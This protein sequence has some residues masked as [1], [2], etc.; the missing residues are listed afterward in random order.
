MAARSN[1]DKVHE[2]R[3]RG[4]VHVVTPAWLHACFMSWERVDERSYALEDSPQRDEPDGGDRPSTVAPDGGPM[5]ATQNVGQPA[6]KTYN[7]N[8]NRQ[9][10]NAGDASD[11]ESERAVAATDAAVDAVD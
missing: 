5:A 6:H 10:T 8:T 9:P 4:N 2:A 3:R 11:R 7:G 1:S